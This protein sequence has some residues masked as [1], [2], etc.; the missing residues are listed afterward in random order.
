VQG[1]PNQVLEVFA[2]FERFHG[3]GEIQAARAQLA[4][5]TMSLGTELGVTTGLQPRHL[6][7]WLYRNSGIRDVQIAKP[8]MTI[9]IQKSELKSM[10]TRS[11]FWSLATPNRSEKMSPGAINSQSMKRPSL[12]MPIPSLDSQIAKRQPA[13]KSSAPYPKHA[14]GAR[15]GAT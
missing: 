12:A 15:W 10:R 3:A 2:A 4:S 11:R 7:S 8:M 6:I 1:L 14:I 13:S 9:N 5:Q